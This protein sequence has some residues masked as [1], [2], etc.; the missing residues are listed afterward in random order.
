M[1]LLFTA[2]LIINFHFLDAPLLSAVKYAFLDQSHDALYKSPKLLMS[3]IDPT[4]SHLTKP[5]PV[6]K[7]ILH[8]SHQVHFYKLPLD[9]DAMILKLAS[10]D[11][12]DS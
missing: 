9:T 2:R 12:I 8:Q 11:C 1:L 4:L 3:W 10:L 6:N 5:V 7:V